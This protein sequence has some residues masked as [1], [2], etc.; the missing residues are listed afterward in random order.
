MRSSLFLQNFCQDVRLWLL[1]S[2]FLSSLKCHHFPTTFHSAVCSM[3]ITTLQGLAEK[4]NFPWVV[5][6]CENNFL[7]SAD[8]ESSEEQPGMSQ[9]KKQSCSEQLKLLTWASDGCWGSTLCGQA[10]L[11]S[12]LSSPVGMT[13]G[14]EAL[15]GVLHSPDTPLGGTAECGLLCLYSKERAQFGSEI[16]SFFGFIMCLKEVVQTRRQPGELLCCTSSKVKT[17]KQLD[18]DI[19]IGSVLHLLIDVFC[20]DFWISLEEHLGPTSL[21]FQ[22]VPV[23]C[24]ASLS[25]GSQLPKDAAGALT[26][27]NSS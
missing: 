5:L 27:G 14:L 10:G 4:A 9:T 3:C 25:R 23:K 22:G 24:T 18:T 1:R 7:H 2:T 6:Y 26:Q 8:F 11:P 16:Y 19:V 21:L 15:R 12:A 13:K 17:M 20:N